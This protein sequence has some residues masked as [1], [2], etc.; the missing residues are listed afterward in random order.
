M[1]L[2]HDEVFFYHEDSK[3]QVKFKQINQE[4]TKVNNNYYE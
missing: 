4:F 3:E 2:N 1:F